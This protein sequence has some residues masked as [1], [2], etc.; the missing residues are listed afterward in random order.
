MYW[1][2]REYRYTTKAKRFCVLVMGVFSLSLIL[3][4]PFSLSRHI[5]VCLYIAR[6]IH[7]QLCQVE[8]LLYG[9]S[10]SSP[11]IRWLCPRCRVH[12][13]CENLHQDTAHV[14]C[15][16]CEPAVLRYTLLHM[17][18]IYLSVLLYYIQFYLP[19]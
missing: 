4:Q 19:L 11:T 17:A 7:S 1:D 2:T 6:C 18:N 5:H 16:I 10:T 9:Q 13:A 8:S 14:V 12:V 3:I 15:S